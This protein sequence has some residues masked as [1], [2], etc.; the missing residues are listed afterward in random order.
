[1]DVLSSRLVYVQDYIGRC[2][3]TLTRV[4]M[5]EEYKD[6]FPLDESK[7]GKL[8]LHLK[9]MAQ[10]IYRDSWSLLED[11]QLRMYILSSSHKGICFCQK[12]ESVDSNLSFPCFL[13]TL[14]NASWANMSQLIKDFACIK[15][16][17]LN[18]I[19]TF[20]HE[21]PC[22]RRITLH[23]SPYLFHS[24]KQPFDTS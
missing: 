22:V 1:M 12:N 23:V 10:S 2:I 8:Q 16:N 24:H 11:S 13:K 17:S 9:W 19:S 21:L 15:R 14:D 5:E 20:Y 18:K 4:I 7:T 3:L 6:W